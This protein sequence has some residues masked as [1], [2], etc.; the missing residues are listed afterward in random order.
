MENLWRKLLSKPGSNLL[1]FWLYFITQY[2]K[3]AAEVIRRYIQYQHRAEEL[4]LD[5]C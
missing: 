3:V 2:D 5:F 1:Y 4:E